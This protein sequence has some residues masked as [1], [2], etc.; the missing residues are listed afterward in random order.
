LC[1]TPDEADAKNEHAGGYHYGAEIGEIDERIRDCGMARAGLDPHRRDPG[2]GGLFLI[3]AVE[4]R[5]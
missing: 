1:R 5:E 2:A 3:R 4:N